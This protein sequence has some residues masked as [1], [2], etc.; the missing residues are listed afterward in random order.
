MDGG[1]KGFRL[2]CSELGTPAFS[3]Y[4]FSLFTYSPG[5]SSQGG[6]PFLFGKR[7]W[8]RCLTP[9][10]SVEPRRCLSH[11]SSHRQSAHFQ[12]AEWSRWRNPVETK[13]SAECLKYLLHLSPPGRLFG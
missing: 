12:I 1:L 3:L 11:C 7:N 4:H 8:L 6:Q 13:R 9:A 10:S 2:K 5:Q